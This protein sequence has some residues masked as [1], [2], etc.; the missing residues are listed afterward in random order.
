MYDIFFI[1]SS[2]D[3]QVDGVHI[4]AIVNSSAMN[5]VHASFRIMVSSWYMLRSGI[6]GSYGSSIFKKPPYCFQ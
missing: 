6:A 2:A 3:E 5:K 1:H 4:L